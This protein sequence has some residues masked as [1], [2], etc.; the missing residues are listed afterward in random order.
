MSFS[1]PHRQLRIVGDV[2]GDIRGFSAACATDRFVIQ[3]G[4]LTDGGTDNAAVLSMALGLLAAKRGLFVLGN[5]D[6]KLCRAIRGDARNLSPALIDT[7]AAL[8]EDLRIRAD[9]AISTAPAWLRTGKLLFVHG[10][11]HSAMLDRPSPPDVLA[12]RPDGLVSRAL[13]GETTGQLQPDGYPERS[14]GWV[15]RIPAGIT[16]YCG[17]SLR[18]TDGRPLRQRGM[19]GGSAV[20]MDTGAGK[21][22]HLSWID[23]D[24]TEK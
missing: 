6:H 18:S 21:G 24:L 23:L 1:F 20:F 11:F 17:H 12:R 4:D 2:H 8:P 13:Y 7:L 10:A 19:A 15:D 5:H 22:G 3:L 9:T 16:V 14:Y